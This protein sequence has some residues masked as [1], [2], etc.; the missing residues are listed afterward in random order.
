MSHN[1]ENGRDSIGFVF[2]A[3]VRRTEG[4]SPNMSMTSTI[5]SDQDIVDT[6]LKDKCRHDVAPMPV[7]KAH[8]DLN[9]R[10][11]EYEACPICWVYCAT[12][13]NAARVPP[14]SAG[15]VDSNQ[16]TDLRARPLE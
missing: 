16:P 3:L 5:N 11:C 13:K 1:G 8:L 6:W 7:F 10:C 9:G 15:F 2:A 12:A 14:D 4:E